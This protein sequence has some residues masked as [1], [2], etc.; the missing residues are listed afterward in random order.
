MAKKKLKVAVLMHPDFIPPPSIEGM[1]EAE[2]LPFKTEFDV[3]AT[4]RDMGHEAFPVG[5]GDDLGVIRRTVDALHPDVAF[6][7]LEEF[8]GVG[9]FDAHVVGYLEMIDLPYTGCNPRGLMLA[10]NKALSK[11][12][13]RHHRIPVPPFHVFPM[14][15]KVRRP[16]KL[17]FP[18]LVKS[19]T[20]EGSVGISQASICTNDD[21]LVDR[22]AFVHEKLRTDAIAERYIDGREVYV[23]V[24][25]NDRLQTLP[26]W[27]L[28]FRKLRPDAPRIAT[29][30]I[31]WDVKYQEKVGIETAAAA[32][33]PGDLATSL[34]KLSKRVYRAL[35]LSGYA[36]LD[37]RIDQEGQP[38]LL[39]ANPNP[40]L[41]YGEDFSESAEHGGLDYDALLAR[42]L[43]LG[44]RYRLRGQA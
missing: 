32:D 27:E 39:E 37:F 20:E 42:I 8:R 19:L 14:A 15:R 13:C 44:L 11:M 43:N 21:Q 25:G 1:T 12:V 31:K 38:H 24:I 7:L 18:L 35:Q 23:G 9:V 4:L 22:V 16:R 3:T 36:R 29:S 33:L 34:P 26:P 28:H 5:V 2:Y 17:A 10:H 30:K 6:N 40:Q 41:M